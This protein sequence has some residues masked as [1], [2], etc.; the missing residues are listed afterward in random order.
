MC[1]IACMYVYIYIYI[2]Y[3]VCVHVL[4]QA[5][6]YIYIYI[7]IHTHALTN[8]A[9][10]RR[11]IFSYCTILDMQQGLGIGASPTAL[12][13]FNRCVHILY[14]HMHEC[15]RLSCVWCVSIWWACI[16]LIRAHAR[17]HLMVMY[18]M[19]K[20]PIVM[21]TSYTC[22]CTNA[23]DCHVYILYVHMHECVRW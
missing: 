11:W 17:V 13:P 10:A 3:H 2:F 6:I 12:C 7:Y 4:I 14:G 15:I 16:H 9:F 1:S 21:Y 5:L 20:H 23:S 22:T 18:M 19:C 8:K